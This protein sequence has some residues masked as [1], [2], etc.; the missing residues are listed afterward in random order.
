MVSKLSSI[1]LQVVDFCGAG[2]LYMLLPRFSDQLLQ[3]TSPGV[4]QAH[5]EPAI[6]SSQ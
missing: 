4:L 5:T 6:L 3:H 1:A 2:T